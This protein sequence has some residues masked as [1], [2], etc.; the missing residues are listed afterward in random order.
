MIDLQV[1][2]RVSESYVF[3]WKVFLLLCKKRGS[4]IHSEIPGPIGEMNFGCLMIILE[5]GD[6]SQDPEASSSIYSSAQKN[7]EHK[8]SS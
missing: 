2:E 8:I 5:G 7:F 1:N 4:E 6:L 3:L